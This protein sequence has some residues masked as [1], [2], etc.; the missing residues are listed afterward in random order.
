MD[1]LIQWLERQDGGI[2]TYLA[3]RDRCSRLAIKEP[4]HS[5]LYT[6]L[7]TLAARFADEYDERPLPVEIADSAATDLLQVAKLASEAIHSPDSAQ[8]R[9][10][11]HV[12]ELRLGRGV[13]GRS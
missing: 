6:L 2:Y 9:F 4:G 13:T 7:G 1:D 3:F 11:N 8:L 5:A 10:L 12:A